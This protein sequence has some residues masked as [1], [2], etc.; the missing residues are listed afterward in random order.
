MSNGRNIVL[1][2]SGLFGADD[3]TT[4]Q[5][6]LQAV[7]DSGFTTV[8]LW[9]LHVQSNGDVYY[10]DT[11]IVQDGQFSEGCDYLPELVTKLKS[12]GTVDK[13]L[14]C[15]GSADV[16]DFENI[17]NLMG[18][19][20][21]LKVLHDNFKAL[22]NTLPID[23]FDF[24]LEEYPFE[25]YTDTVVQLTLMLHRNYGMTVTYC[26]YMDESFWLNCLAQV[27]AQ[28]G[29]QQIVG[30][31]NLQCDAGGVGNDPGYWAGQIK[32]YSSPLGIDNPAAFVIP[33]YW[34]ANS[35]GGGNCDGGDCPASMQEIFAGLAKADPGINGGFVWNSGDIFACESS[36]QCQGAM[37]PQAYAQAIIKGL[38]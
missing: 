28:N 20:F 4:N 2:G 5:R 31:F 18:T 37:T 6:Q 1:Y 34:C 21:G 14:F 22:V 33:G 32:N 7:Q 3:P 23:G 19:R 25:S 13:V 16:S 38:G 8:I 30:W 26:P 36:G 10:N 29:N 15:I 17:Q 12:G 24:D 27:Y 9:T 11:L 35:S